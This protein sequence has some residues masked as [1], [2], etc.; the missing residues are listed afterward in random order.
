MRTKRS[1]KTAVWKGGKTR[2]SEFLGEK[3]GDRNKVKGRATSKKLTT[4]KERFFRGVGKKGGGGELALR[5][6]GIGPK[7]C[8]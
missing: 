4:R 3:K 1:P 5:D 8:L 6:R 2:T 7:G